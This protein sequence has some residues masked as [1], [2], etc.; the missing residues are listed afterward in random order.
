[1]AGSCSGYLSVDN[2]VSATGCADPEPPRNAHVTRDNNKATVTCNFTSHTWH[3]VC[4]N[5]QWIGQTADCDDGL[6]L[7]TLPA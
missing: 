5:T 2:N 6:Y 3:L 4:K 1:M 7:F